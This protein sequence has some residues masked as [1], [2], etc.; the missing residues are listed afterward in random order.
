[1]RV[2]VDGFIEPGA[3]S[4]A[5]GETNRRVLADFY[6]SSM[7]ISDILVLYP[8][9]RRTSKVLR[10][11]W[12]RAV[13]VCRENS[14]HMLYHEAELFASQ[15]RSEFKYMSMPCWAYS[16]KIEMLSSDFED[17]YTQKIFKCRSWMKPTASRRSQTTISPVLWPVKNR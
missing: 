15:M 7:Q 17:P 4:N 9:D 11:P 13:Q 5:Q 10:S 6:A 2:D 16:R 3:V 14:S 1:M 8:V 12:K